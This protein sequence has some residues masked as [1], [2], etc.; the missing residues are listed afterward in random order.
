MSRIRLV[1]RQGFIA[2]L[3]GTSVAWPFVAR[4]QKPAKIPHV[5]IISPAR[6]PPDRY[7]E[8]LR[9]FGYIEGRN[10]RLEFRDAGGYADRLPALAE[11]L[12]Q[13]GGIDVVATISL[14][15]A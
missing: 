5:V 6:L 3:G 14:P 10:I 2:L 15:A 1:R 9:D 11:Q 4:A 8:L 7:P 13:E 12:V